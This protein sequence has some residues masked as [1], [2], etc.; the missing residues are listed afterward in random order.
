MRANLVNYLYFSGLSKGM[1]VVININ[2]S[3][4]QNAQTYF[5]KAKQ[6]R[7]KLEGVRKALEVSLQRLE[8]EKKCRDEELRKLD[9]QHK[10]KEQEQKRKKEWYE[11]FRWFLSSEGFLVIGGRDATTN[12]IIVKKHTEKHDIVFH[13]DMAGSPFFVVKTR[14]REPGERTMQE[15]ADATLCFSRAWRMGLGT[16]PTFWV[17]PEQVTKGANAGEYLPKGAFMI[18]GR[19][20]YV[21]VTPNCAVG[22]LEDGRIMCAPTSAVR[23]N[24]NEYIELIQGRKKPSDIAKLVKK[25]F[26]GDLDDI[27]K[28]LPGGGLDIKH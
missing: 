3:V 10:R 7:K 15:A 20:N 28:V 17:R 26:G 11:K 25:R 8:N 19:T 18:R 27:I 1:K 23:H 16:V 5:E 6:A 14:G 9:A 21:H 12:E 13:T 2:K 24:C 22:K 4:E